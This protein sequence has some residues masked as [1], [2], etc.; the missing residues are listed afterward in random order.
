VNT[1]VLVHSPLVGP[2]TWS[3]V[4]GELRH[5]GIEAFT[6]ALQQDAAA[7]TP[8]WKQHA[9]CVAD[10]LRTL[11]ADRAVILAGHSGAGPLLPAIR[12][13][14]DRPV[15]AYI[16]VDAGLPQ[17]GQPRLGA[18]A[19]AQ[20]LREIYARGERFPNWSDESLRAVVPDP[21]LRR[22]LRPQPW[23]FWEEPIPVF[24]GWPDAPCAFLRFAP[25]PAY[26]AAAAEARR[27]GW[28]YAELAGAHF[29]MLVDPAGVTEAL[30]D[31]VREVT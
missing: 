4:A 24:A 21:A 11:P 7:Q 25:N 2:L 18:G 15:A 20:Q 12:Q 10:G 1:W 22:G 28:P 14:A 19:F 27:R 5:R 6:P 9:R 17:D 26:D 13:E 30:L 23:A 8:F 29:H 16:F 31:L 3:R